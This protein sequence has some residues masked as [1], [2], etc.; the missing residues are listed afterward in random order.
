MAT[1]EVMG[2][3]MAGQIYKIIEAKVTLGRGIRCDIRI[4]SSMVSRQHAQIL[5]SKNNY[6]IEDLNSRNGTNLNGRLLMG[7]KQLHD[8][9][10]VQVCDI[11]FIFHNKPPCNLSEKEQN[12]QL[13]SDQNNPTVLFV[14]NAEED[15]TFIRSAYSTVSLTSAANAETSA[16]V[17]LR[18]LLEVMYHLGNTLDLDKLLANILNSLFKIFAL[19]DRGFIVMKNKQGIMQPRWTKVRNNEQ[20]PL[21]ISRIIID[22]VMKS[23]EIVLSEDAGSDQRFDSSKSILAYKIHSV[24]CAP[25]I[26]SD[27][28]VFGVLQVDSLDRTQRFNDQ[29]LEVLGSVAAQTAI[30]INNAQLHEY[31]LEQRVMER[32]LELAHQVQQSFLPEQQPDIDGYC[33]YHLYKPAEKVGGDFFDYIALPD[34][35][36][37]VIVADVSGHGVAAA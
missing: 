1:I 10:R 14:N 31:S 28:Q 15:S 24:M 19:A 16:E 20:E 2:G 17:K 25:L 7:C 36:I 12:S 30:A 3:P 29:D 22:H 33:F 13:S 34:G 6:F 18:A 26:N 32:D 8:G 21:H 23:K 11:P 27:G 37:A 9:D 4:D 5:S 35:R